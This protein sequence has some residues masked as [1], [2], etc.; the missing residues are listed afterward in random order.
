MTLPR[1][2][3][4]YPDHLAT[5]EQ[6]KAQRLK[7]GTVRPV[8]LLEVSGPGHQALLGLF[9]RAAVLPLEAPSPRDQAM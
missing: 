1:Y 6:L 3:N 2:R 7:P 9:E 8:A 5:P 4:T